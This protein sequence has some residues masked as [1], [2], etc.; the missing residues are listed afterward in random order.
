MSTT[1]RFFLINF[2]GC[3]AFLSIP[4]FSSPDFSE[5]VEIIYVPPF[6]TNIFSYI[7]LLFFF[8]LNYYYLIP[9][10]YFNQKRVIY[11]LL[12]IGCFALFLTLP[13]L[14]L[15]VDFVELSKHKM[16]QERPIPRPNPLHPF[17]LGDSISF[18]LV[19]SLS[20]LIKLNSRLNEIHDEKLT[21]E[22]SYLKAQIN[23]HF[24]FNTLNSLYALTLQ[25]SN[26]APNA[27]LKLSGIMRYVVTESSQDFVALD[28]EINYI[29]D[30]LELQKLRLDNG[31]SLSFDIHGTTTGRAIAPLILIPFIENAFKYGINPDKDSYIKIVIE[32]QNQSLSMRVKNSIVA[33]EIDEELKTEEGLKNTQKRLDLIYP[34]KY[35]LK[36]IEDGKEYEVNLKLELL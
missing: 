29:K 20:F 18:A 9:K 26:D 13:N 11:L 25:K 27:V 10:F 19:L 14:I 16:Y 36:V 4:V 5:G 34:G 15:P 8:Y 21:A 22:V 7:L 23:P 17:N 2:L 31:V 28:K 32:I 6:Q 12:L 35:D 3:L 1:T 24:L 30:Y 33:S